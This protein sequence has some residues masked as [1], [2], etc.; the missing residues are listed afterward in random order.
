MSNAADNNVTVR[1]E[2]DD[3]L[4][5]FLRLSET[6]ADFDHAYIE[7]LLS[8][9]VNINSVDESNGA[10][11]MHMVARNWDVTVAQF[12]YE[13]GIN[14]CHEDHTGKTPLHVAASSNHHVMVEWLIN[15]GADV[16]ARTMIQR[17]TPVH[18][19]AR[20]DAVLAL[21]VLIQNGGMCV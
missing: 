10:T 16:E 12:L 2:S 14:I 18:H 17:Q 21:E 6:D 13:K 4:Q 19:A 5:Y 3:L 8:N 7:T 15:Q 20:N 1:Q 9:G 11:I